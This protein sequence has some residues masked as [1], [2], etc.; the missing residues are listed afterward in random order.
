M[1]VYPIL[2]S[3]AKGGC[4]DPKMTNDIDEYD[5]YDEF[6]P[7]L[8]LQTF[9]QEI[10]SEAFSL[11]QFLH[12]VFEHQPDGC[13]VLEFGGGPTLVGMLSAA[14]VA[15]EIHFA[16]YVP[17][18]RNL[19]SY[20]LAGHTDKFDWR[21]YAEATLRLEGIAEPDEAAID[22][23]MLAL[24]NKVTQV[25]VGDIYDH[26]PVATG[27]QYDVVISNYCLD[28][29]TGDYD[30]WLSFLKSLS[31]HVRPQG[32]LSLAALQ[33]V[34]HCEY[35]GVRYP[36]VYMNE[37]NLR[38]GLIA[39]G[40]APESIQITSAPADNHDER[41]YPGVLFAVATKL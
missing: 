32:T 5:H 35:W 8:Y 24:R 38:Q 15:S 41:N 22:D 37:A 11:L 10:G 30:E 2:N 3:D 39:A 25:I 36:N 29:V 20:W 12:H 17:I 7:L 4:F 9:Y 16:E 6:D 34:D 28:S 27:L 26:P 14:R 21:P 33:E 23:R 1:S 31:T 18:N 19:V 13:T 40:Y